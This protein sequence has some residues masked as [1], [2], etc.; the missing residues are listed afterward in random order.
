MTNRSEGRRPGR[1]RSSDNAKPGGKARPSGPRRD[2]GD[3]TTDGAQDRGGRPASKRAGKRP[4]GAVRRGEEQATDR[5]RSTRA[6]RPGTGEGKARAPF[7]RAAGAGK[8]GGERSA[9][10]SRTER[11]QR[12]GMGKRPFG[13]GAK[14]SKKSS[15]SAGPKVEGLIRLNRYLAQSGICS[16]R[17]ADDLIKAGVVSVNGKIV[18]EMGAKVY[19]TDKVHYGGQ[20]LSMEKKRYVLLNKPKGF[21]TTTD[22]PHDRKTVMHLVAH[23]C[24]ERLYPVGR[25]DRLTTGVL[26]MTN[27]GDLAKK[28]THPS[29]GAEK[30]YHVTTDKSV[31]KAHLVQLVEGIT[32]EDGPAQAD[33]ANYVD[34]AGKR[35]VGIKIHMGRNRI[36]R[37]MFEHLGYEVVKLDRVVFA[38]LTKK[39]LPRSKWRHLTENEVLFLSK[40]K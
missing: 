8:P 34:G 26:L 21:I 31:T 2:T 14:R 24:P 33:E 10:G 11:P 38:G 23:A 37:R 4:P 19:A 3:R 18:T 28:L 13:A 25:L 12:P 29:H 6:E 16:R 15:S 32:L 30:I 27:D 17:E 5:G 36:V 9:A 39:D 40:R 20:R 35:E 1:G 22:D 7:K